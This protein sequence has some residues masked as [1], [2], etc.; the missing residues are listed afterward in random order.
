RKVKEEARID[1]EDLGSS[2]EKDHLPVAL[3]NVLL[4]SIAVYGALFAIGYGLYGNIMLCV[5]LAVVSLCSGTLVVH[6]W[7]QTQRA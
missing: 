5:I 1:G 2:A 6:L 3:L 4:A 7:R